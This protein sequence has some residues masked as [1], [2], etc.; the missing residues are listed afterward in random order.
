MVGRWF[1][2]ARQRRLVEW[3]A[4][5]C[6][7]NFDDDSDDSVAVWYMGKRNDPQN[8]SKSL[9]YIGKMTCLRVCVCVAQVIFGSCFLFLGCCSYFSCVSIDLGHD[10]LIMLQLPAFKDLI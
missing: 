6:A 3:A 9:G 2:S 4:R 5:L 8:I 10:L 7:G 1:P